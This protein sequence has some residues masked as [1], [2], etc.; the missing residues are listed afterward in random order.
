MKRYSCF[1]FFFFQW[2]LAFSAITFSSSSTSIDTLPDGRSIYDLSPEEL[3]LFSDPRTRVLVTGC[4]QDIELGLGERLY[5]LGSMLTAA[6]PTLKPLAITKALPGLTVAETQIVKSARQIWNSQA[7]KSGIRGMRAGKNSE[8][9]VDGVKV[10]FQADGPFSGMTLF[11]ERGF[12]IGKEALRSPDEIVKTVLHEFYRLST[13]AAGP[14]SGV[15]QA[16]VAK[17]TNNVVNFVERAFKSIR[18]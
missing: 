17:E 14:N 18:Q 3:A 5:L 10:V 16:L 7:F 9:T 13:S 1:V 15:S 8:I 4:R 12:V 6:S 2:V 11:G